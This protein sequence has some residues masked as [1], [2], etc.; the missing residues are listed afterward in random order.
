MNQSDLRRLAPSL[1]PVDAKAA[2]TCLQTCFNWIKNIL[3]KLGVVLSQPLSRYTNPLVV[4][5]FCFSFGFIGWTLWFP[6]F[7]NSTQT[8]VY[9]ENQ[10]ISKNI[11]YSDNAYPN[12]ISI[13][14]FEYVTFENVTFSNLLINDTEFYRCVFEDCL[15]TNILSTTT[16]FNMTTFI[17]TE[18]KRTD[19]HEHNFIGT[20]RPRFLDTRGCSSVVAFAPTAAYWKMFAGAIC[21]VSSVCV[22]IAVLEL[23]GPKFMFGK[24]SSSNNK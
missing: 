3:A 10:Q 18:F 20:G 21:G 5:V 4:C 17:N 2:E 24:L 12:D 8:D 23:L 7:I 11:N 16:I 9:R 13:H 15:F 22:G 1:P 19:F 6:V 14:R